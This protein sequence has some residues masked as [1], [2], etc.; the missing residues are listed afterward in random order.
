MPRSLT[1]ERECV[2]HMLGI[3]S[4]LDEAQYRVV[5]EFP[6]GAVKLAPLCGMR[7][8][9]LSNK[10]NPEYDGTQLFVSEAVAIQHTANRF[11]ILYAE[12]AL[13][14]HTSIPLGD[15]S[16]VSDTELLTVYA[17]YHA[18]LGETAA[19]ISSALEDGRITRAEFEHIKREGY[20]DI[21]RFFEFLARLE[22]LIDE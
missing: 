6:G 14:N 9:T 20:E 19:A 1:S 16:R 22:A 2:A 17:R 4:P 12:S 5:H 8:G 18:E 21:Q 13:L 3:F 10:V 7:P 11:D 15:Y